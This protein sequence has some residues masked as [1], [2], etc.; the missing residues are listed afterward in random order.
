[1]KFYLKYFPCRFKIALF[2]SNPPRLIRHLT[3]PHTS[4]LN[5]FGSY[6]HS[7]R[8]AA[9]LGSEDCN[10]QFIFQIL[11][12]ATMATAGML[13]YC[14]CCCLHQLGLDGQRRK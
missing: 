11:E 12:A 8:S 5:T 9:N 13:L 10:Y 1:M 3:G 2:A 14:S 4:H 6:F 7:Q